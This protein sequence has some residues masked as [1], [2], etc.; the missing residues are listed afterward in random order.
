MIAVVPTAVLSAISMTLVA[1]AADSPSGSS[2]LPD[3]S[4]FVIVLY[5]LVAV[6]VS[7][8]GLLYFSGVPVGRWLAARKPRPHPAIENSED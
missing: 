3:L 1:D 4:V 5:T 6:E 8:V 2:D 7:A